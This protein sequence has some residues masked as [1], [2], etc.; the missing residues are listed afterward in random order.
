MGVQCTYRS[1]KCMKRFTHPDLFFQ[2]TGWHIRFFFTPLKQNASWPPFLLFFDYS[3]SQSVSQS[4]SYSFSDTASSIFSLS[5]SLSFSLLSSSFSYLSISS[6]LS[7]AAFLSFF[8][9]Y[10]P[11]YCRTLLMNHPSKEC[12]SQNSDANSARAEINRFSSL[13]FSQVVCLSAFS[14]V[15][16]FVCSLCMSVIWAPELISRRQNNSLPILCFM[17]YVEVRVLPVSYSNLTCLGV[18]SIFYTHRYPFIL[19]YT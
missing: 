19:V 4:V 13:F 12:L 7:V 1:T 3:V 5:F 18:L 6:F 16:P 17:M 15:S 9:V 14:T 11:Y 8:C 2:M 10:P